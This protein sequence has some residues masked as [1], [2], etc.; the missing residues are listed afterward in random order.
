M[1]FIDVLYEIVVTM[2]VSHSSRV[3]LFSVDRRP[4]AMKNVEVGQGRM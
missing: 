2:I 4:C 3:K 1:S